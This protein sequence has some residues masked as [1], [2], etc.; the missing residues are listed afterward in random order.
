MPRP[1][2]PKGSPLIY[3]RPFELSDPQKTR[4]IVDILGNDMGTR[5]DKEKAKQIAINIEHWIGAYFEF[6]KNS[7]P[8]EAAITKEISTIRHNAIKLMNEVIGMSGWASDRLEKL[9]YNDFQL[10]SALAKFRDITAKIVGSSEVESR[11]QPPKLAL[12]MLINHLRFQF[13]KSYVALEDYADDDPNGTQAKK[14]KNKSLK[15]FITECL[16]FAKIEHPDNIS[17][18]FYTDKTPKDER[19]FFTQIP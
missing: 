13:E 10:T 3:S 1:Q 5:K 11:G 14:A 15:S 12:Q 2:K 16:Q 7:P 9:G 6:L 19:W 4:L 18:L 17:S 8:T